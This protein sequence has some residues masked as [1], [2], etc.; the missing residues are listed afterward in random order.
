MLF[1]MAGPL[2]VFEK[3]MEELLHETDKIEQAESHEKLQ[4]LL[5]LLKELKK[6]HV[7]IPC[8]NEPDKTG[9]EIETSR[10]RRYQRSAEKE[11][12]RHQQ[13]GSTD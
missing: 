4:E 6:I 5:E 11:F 13:E 8:R 3:R 7:E 1:E 12:G 9:E 10:D 2:Y